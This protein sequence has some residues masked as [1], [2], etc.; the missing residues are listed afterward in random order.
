M[1]QAMADH[2]PQVRYC[3]GCEINRSRRGPLFEIKNSHNQQTFHGAN[4]KK[5]GKQTNLDVLTWY[6]IAV[7]GPQSY[8][9]LRGTFGLPETRNEDRRL[10]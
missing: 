4:K 3:H 5:N 6:L 8:T 7:N 2:Y 9:L 1:F 10:N